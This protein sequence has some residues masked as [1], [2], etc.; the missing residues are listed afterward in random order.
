MEGM[1]ENSNDELFQSPLAIEV[2][3]WTKFSV[4]GKIINQKYTLCGLNSVQPQYKKHFLLKKTKK[5]IKSLMKN[6]KDTRECKII[7][8]L[9]RKWNQ[10]KRPNYIYTSTVG[11]KV[12]EASKPSSIYEEKF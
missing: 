7:Y 11:V 12:L 2:L 3:K 10:E 1:D 5:Q 8:P 4:K 9:C 6:P